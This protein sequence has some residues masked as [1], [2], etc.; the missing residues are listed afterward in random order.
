MRLVNR[1]AVI[2]LAFALV[3]GS[4][5]SAAEV[6]VR[7]SGNTFIPDFVSI[8]QG[9]TV[10]WNSEE[11]LHTTTGDHPLNYWDAEV[12]FEESFSFVFTA[13]GRFPY[14]CDIHPSMVGT[15]VVKLRVAPKSGPVGTSFVVRLATEE[16]TSPFVF[17]VHKKDPGGGFQVWMTGLTSKSAEFD[18][19]GMPTGSYK[20]QSRVRNTSTGGVSDWSLPTSIRVT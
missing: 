12:P 14:H 5:A 3:S 9:D 11:G 10:T 1:I 16:P 18:S 8:K 20:F 4:P 13:A 15:V 19:A 2:G 6:I 7:M 17:D